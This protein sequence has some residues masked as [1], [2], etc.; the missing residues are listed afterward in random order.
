VI[1][2]AELPA[3]LTGSNLSLQSLSHG[4]TLANVVNEHL[5]EIHS[6]RFRFHYDG[7]VPRSPAVILPLDQLL[8][9]RIAEVVRL[10]RSLAGRD[11]GRSSAQLSKPQKN[12]HI[13]ALQAIDGRR[14]GA[15]YRVIAH[16]L[17]GAQEVSQ[18]GWKTHDLRDRTIRLVRFGMG[19]MQDGYRRLLLFPYRRRN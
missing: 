7:P 19:M 17:F 3:E 11:P 1:A 12:R 15:S 9:L 6:A 14:E 4:N 16:A 8:S 10:S 5:I 18:R 2:L 13:L